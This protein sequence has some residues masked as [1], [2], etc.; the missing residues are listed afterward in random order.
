MNL[1]NIIKSLFIFQLALFAASVLIL[2]FAEGFNSLAA[3]YTIIPIIALSPI[4]A[5]LG[6]L[7]LIK[8]Q[9]GSLA[10]YIALAINLVISLILLV[11]FVIISFVLGVR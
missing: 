10:V 8:R 3:I 11:R 1:R 7:L 4:V 9:A 6:I 2:T 5:L